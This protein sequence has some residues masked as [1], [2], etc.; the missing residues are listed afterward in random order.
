MTRYGYA[1][2]MGGDPEISAALA[3]GMKAGTLE[4]EREA[5]RARASEAVRR[6]AMWQHSPEEWEDMIEEARVIYGGQR[7]MPRWAE[8]LLVGHAMLWYGLHL[9]AKGLERML[10]EG[11]K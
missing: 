10:E 11:A 4:R 9:A 2:R 6:V 1:I 8:W 7:R 5:M 3:E